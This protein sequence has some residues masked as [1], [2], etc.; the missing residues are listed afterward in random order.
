MSS[1]FFTGPVVVC[2]PFRFQPEIHWVIEFTTY[3]L[4][5]RISIAVPSGK[6]SRA[7]MAARS[8]MRLLV[9]DASPPLR[10]T[11]PPGVSI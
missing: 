7:L 8:S 1:T 10:E 3:W 2:Q 9:V 4:S 5:H 11:V 6:Y